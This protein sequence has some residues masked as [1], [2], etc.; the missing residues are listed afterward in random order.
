MATADRTPPSSALKPQRIETAAG[1]ADAIGDE[2]LLG[3]RKLA[4]VRSRKCPG[5][6]I[7]QTYDFAR[8]VRSCGIAVVSGFHSPIEKDCLP[9]VLRGPCP[10]IIV[11]G[12]RLS[13]SRLPSEWQKAIDAGRLLL[14]SPFTQK[15]RRVTAELAA[16]RN[17]FVAAISD[18]VLI[19]YAAPGSRTEAL[20]LDLLTSGKRVYT[21]SDR[22]GPL[23]DAGAEVVAPEFFAHHRE[24]ADGPSGIFKA[25]QEEV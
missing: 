17:R 25:K 1:E 10:V 4:L 23:L 18:E 8:L 2:S 24:P 3:G 13:V 22:P 15:E 20:A 11:Q 14:L 21:F 12:H 5:D 7:L 16:E 9:I 19:P 6:V